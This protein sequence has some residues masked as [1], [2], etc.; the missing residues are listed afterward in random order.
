MIFLG[1]LVVGFAAI[2]LVPV[3][4][5]N[6][7]VTSEPNW[8]SPETRALAQRAC[9]DCHSNETQWPWYAYVAPVSW[10]V[11]HDTIEGRQRLNFSEWDSMRGEARE[12]HEIIEVILEGEMPPSNY[13]RM[14]PEANLTDAERSQ[15]VEGLRATL[16]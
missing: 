14:H 3:S 2:Q 7:P 1:I 11:S 9:F 5:T 4:R 6:P 15:L 13:V 16:R 10:L 12:T 8:D